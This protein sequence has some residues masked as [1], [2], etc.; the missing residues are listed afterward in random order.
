MK[1]VFVE[2]PDGSSVEVSVA[3]NTELDDRFAATCLLTGERLWVNGW[4]ATTIEPL[5]A[6][7]A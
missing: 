4:N 3:D 7:E 6:M 2:F 5:E 1:N